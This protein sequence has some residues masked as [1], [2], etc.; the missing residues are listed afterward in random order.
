MKAVVTP[1]DEEKGT[2]PYNDGEVDD[3]ERDRDPVVNHFQA[4][5]A[6]Q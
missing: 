4:Q 2:I 6:S 3:K 1:N 5:K